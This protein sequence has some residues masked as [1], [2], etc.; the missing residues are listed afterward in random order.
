MRGGGVGG[1]RSVRQAW[2]DSEPGRACGQVKEC[3]PHSQKWAGSSGKMLVHG[4]KTL[5]T[6]LQICHPVT[7]RLAEEVVGPGVGRSIP[8]VG[9]LPGSQWV[10]PPSTFFCKVHRLPSLVS[11]LPLLHL[12]VPRPTASCLTHKFPFAAV[13]IW[14][15]DPGLGL[16]ALRPCL[17]VVDRPL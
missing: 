5:G 2:R 3:R 9:G 16:G 1:P 14:S 15:A 4:P 8:L 10:A 13:G 6:W 11:L 12:P 7:W 17:P